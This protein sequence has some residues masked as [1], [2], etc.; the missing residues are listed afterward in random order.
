MRSLSRQRSSRRAFTLSLTYATAFCAS[1]ASAARLTLTWPGTAIN[2]HGFSSE[3]KFGSA[4]SFA[5]P[6][7][8]PADT[9][10]Y[11]D[12]AVGAGETYCSRTQARNFAD[13]LLTPPRPAAPWPRRPV[14][15]QSL[16]PA[17]AAA[18]WTAVHPTSVS[19]SARP[20]DLPRAT[21]WI[22][23]ENARQSN[24]SFPG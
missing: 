15:A 19:A 2:E 4:R 14:S 17:M 1:P 11:R 20:K 7:T 6:A 18:S 24:L 23:A 3:R 9:A 13:A 5:P 21:H 22:G 10:S 12:S 16:P 8:V